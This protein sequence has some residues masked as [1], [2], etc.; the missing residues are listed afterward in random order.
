MIHVFNHQ[1]MATLF[2]VRLAGEEAAY[3]AQAAR[4]AFAEADRL[5]NVLSRFRESSDISAA[6]GLQPG[7]TLRLSEAAFACLTLA[8]EM[9]L[10]TEGAF[11]VNV[12]V[13]P[14]HPEVVGEVAR[15]RPLGGRPAGL[16]T[17]ETAD[18]EVC[19]TNDPPTA[20]GCA[21]AR[22]TQPGPPRWSLP[23]P[24]TLRCEA[25]RLEFDLGAI[26]KGFALDRMARE[27]AEWQCPAYLLIAGGSSILA[28]DPPP[29]SPGWSVGLGEDHSEPRQWL[30]HGSL[31]GSG[32]AVKGRH[33]YDPRTGQAAQQRVRAWATA[34]EAAVSDALSTA[35]MVLT[36]AEIARVLTGRKDWRAFL[37]ED[38]K[39]R[40]L[41]GEG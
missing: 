3:A 21:A 30:Q 36:E 40:V 33:I 38:G 28:G 25:G 41:G 27:L 35:F 2:Q 8:R 7:E 32:T 6:A 5:E 18:L 39:W 11:S 4:A 20:S 12:P 26:G 29:D 17:R 31:S 22:Q 37:Q 15:A 10:A 34:P 16:E 9:E 13:R 1:A 19:G 23:A 14:G 24:F